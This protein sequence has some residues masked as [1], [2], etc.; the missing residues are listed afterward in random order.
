MTLDDTILE[1]LTVSCL[2]AGDYLEISTIKGEKHVLLT[3]DGVTTS[4]LN[5]L[6]PD[7]EWFTLQRGNN[8]FYFT[9]SFGDQFLE[10]MIEYE[11][12]YEGI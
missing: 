4:V 11:L 6:G 12:V 2:V 7:S 5:A 9:A 8:T 3:R 1:A 10:F